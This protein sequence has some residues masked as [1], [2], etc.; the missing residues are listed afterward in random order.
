MGKFSIYA[1]AILLL[2][3]QGCAPAFQAKYFDVE[4]LKEGSFNLD[5]EGREVSVFAVSPKEAQDSALI[6]AAAKGLA[7]K[8]ET[9]QVLEPESVAIYSIPQSEFPGFVNS[10][11]R[12]PEYYES[13]MMGSASQL[14]IFLSNLQFS[15]LGVKGERYMTI[16]YTVKMDVYDAIKDSLLLSKQFRDTL[17]AAFLTGSNTSQKTI[18]DAAMKSLPDFATKI[19]E[20]AANELSTKWE[21]EEWMLIYA[22]NGA[23]EK[24]V[25]YAENFNW[26]EAVQTWLPLA[27][28]QDA[29]EASYAAFN[30][31]VGCQMLGETDL[32]LEWIRYAREKADFSEYTALEKYLENKRKQAAK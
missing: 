24:G 7:T 16:P 29:K 21:T 20:V 12:Q 27:E 28:S 32:A 13:L 31:A 30:I 11:G 5:P 22:P 15:H 4:V 25:R 1:A 9:S 23:W 17:H 18:Y 2:I 26:E 3:L 14:L 19:G 6:S 10:K 8:Y